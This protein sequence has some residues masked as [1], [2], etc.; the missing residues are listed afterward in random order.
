M[1]FPLITHVYFIFCTVT[2]NDIVLFYKSIGEYR[3]LSNAKQECQLC[4][5][6]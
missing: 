5:A 3:C 6:S 1:L 4:R 2:R